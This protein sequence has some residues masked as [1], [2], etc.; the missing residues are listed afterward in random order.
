[1]EEVLNQQQ[2][3]QFIHEGFVRIDQAFSE[4]IAAQVRSI[5]WKDLG[6]DPTDP[7]TWT[8]PVIRLGMYSQEP[9]IQAACTPILHAAF[10]QLVGPGK[11]IPCKS[12]GIF[13]V[14]FPSPN[15]PGDTG[16]HVDAS[17]PGS[18]PTNYFE[19]RVNVQSK[20][21]AL[22][23]L[24]LF[25]NVSENDAPTRIRV[26]SHLDVAKVL[27]PAGETGLPFME[28]AG[29]LAELTERQEILATG[30]AGTVYLCHPFLVHGA[31]PHHGNEPRF[32]AQPPLILKEDLQI[33][34][35]SG[36]YT[37]VE[38]AIRLGVNL[39]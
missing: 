24:F 7:T 18:E 37:P 9:F 4:E 36:K 33:E 20:G 5:L 12:M 2:I 13:P 26:G 19:W 28:L 10:D 35:K 14:R 17:F 6:C 21:R 34:G 32:L 8:K 38:E 29:K 30:K 11:W 22:L 27:Q 23:M 1:M 25:S 16:W 39:Q 15:D 3:D 31:Q